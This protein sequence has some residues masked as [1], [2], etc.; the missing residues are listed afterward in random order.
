M[1]RSPRYLAPIAGLAALLFT[2]APASAQTAPS[3]G[4]AASFAV[5]GGSTV[6]NT[7]TSVITGDLGVSPG[8]A[9]TG[10][11]PGLVV[12]G[13]IHM[14][15]A[16]ALQA[17]NDVTT[18]YNALAAQPC[19]QNLSG[20][21]LGNRVLTPGV[22]CFDAS[23]QLTGTLTLNA[24]GNPAAVF[25]FKIGSTLTT[26]S[27]SLVVV[28]NGGQNCNVFWQIGSSATLGTNSTIAGN[29][30]ALTSITATTQARVFGRT[31]ARNGAV[32][33]DTNSVDRSSCSTAVPVCPAITVAPAT[34]PNGTVAIAYSQQIT[35]SGGTGPYAFAV[36]SGTLPA[37]LV[38]TPSGLVAGTPT[39]AG[40][41]TF[42]V[43]A[44][45]ANGCFQSITY[46]LV[47]AAAPVPP[48]VCPA[49]TLAPA[50]LPG[51]TQGVAYSQTITA[52]GGT[53][54]YSFGVTVGALP[55]GLTLSATGVLTGTPTSAGTSAF[56]VRVTDSLGCFGTVAYSIVVSA[57]VCPAIALTPATL[58]NAT[59]GVAFSQTLS[60]SGG[61]APY[62][63]TVSS[64]ILPAGLTLT[65]AGVLAGTPTVAGSASF[66][67]R[68]TD[69][70]GCFTT[71]A[72][73][74]TVLAPVP[75]LPQWAMLVLM[76]LLGVG[77]YLRLRRP[78]GARAS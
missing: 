70:N 30:I 33:L 49:I 54:P 25:V 58:P 8:T 63:F 20:Q 7:G 44:T 46:T 23:A 11:P 68:A 52:S 59:Q 18:A 10:F 4:T 62:A 1:N 37:G 12:G 75:T 51:G 16:V 32:T 38:L 47:I 40:S 15:D 61:T 48:A 78:S 57:A 35:A 77:G 26:A 17:Q 6:T 34:L 55:V 2:I 42:T 66:S 65:S 69:A 39:T 43:R 56:T 67:I 28:N 29:I 76:T 64:G 74:F 14:A 71:L 13:T 41:S 36:T 31:L 3:L 53:A 27:S 21:D 60:A 73:S 19:T 22:Y 5:L 72:Y 50:V 9:V 45:D 24:L